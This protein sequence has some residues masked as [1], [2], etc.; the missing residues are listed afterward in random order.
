MPHIVVLS[1]IML[2]ILLACDGFGPFPETVAVAEIII[3]LVTDI[4]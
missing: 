3:E 1:I 4:I 2:I